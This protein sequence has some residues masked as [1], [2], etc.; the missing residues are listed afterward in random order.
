M[1]ELILWKDRE[2]DKLRRDIDR[3]FDRCR[4]DFGTSCFLG[5]VSDDFPIKITETKEILIVR[6]ALEGVNPE[7]LD[8]SVTND[9]LLTIR[10][11][12]R[13]K[14]VEGSGYYRRVERR[15]RSFSRT[16]R[17]P[18]RVKVGEIKATY[19][20]GILNILMPKWAPEKAR[21]IKIT[22]E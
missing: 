14:S 20:D 18:C 12:K 4:S 17:L 15:F 6:A 16:L 21:G 13:E 3:L 5:D 9:T 1:S 22:V 11:E 2:I 10:G 19:K 7:D 8:V